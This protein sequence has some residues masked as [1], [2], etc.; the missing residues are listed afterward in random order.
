MLISGAP[1]RNPLD[2]RH[3]L[4]NHKIQILR[5]RGLQEK[6]WNRRRLLVRVWHGGTGWLSTH[7]A[8]VPS[9]EYF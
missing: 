6:A 8:T 3:R 2:P 5:V 9:V 1:V 7:W 4:V